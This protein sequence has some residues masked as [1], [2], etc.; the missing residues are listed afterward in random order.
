MNVA[1]QH[2]VF[3]MDESYIQNNYA[4]NDD[5]FYDPND[6]KDML[7][8]APHNGNL[9]CIIAAVIDAD[10]RELEEEKKTIEKAHL[11][12]DTLEIFR[13]RKKQAGL[14]WNF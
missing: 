1:I 9:Y 12:L 8:K 14:P 5:G 7:M 11:M 6:E 2:R 3:H 4:L 13:G 10:F